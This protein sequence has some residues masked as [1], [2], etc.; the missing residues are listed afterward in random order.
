M[1][2]LERKLAERL[3]KFCKDKYGMTAIVVFASEHNVCQEIIDLIDECGINDEHELYKVLF[4]DVI[5][6]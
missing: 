6:E 5:E 3:L 2:D 4:S 1:T